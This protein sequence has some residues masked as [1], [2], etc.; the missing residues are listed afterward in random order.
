MPVEFIEVSD[1]LALARVVELAQ[2][3]GRIALDT[4]FQRTRT[5]YPIAGLYQLK[6]KQDCYLIDPIAI[7]DMTPLQELLDT[8]KVVK[9]MHACREDLTLFTH[10]L[11]VWPEGI[12][13]TQIAASFAGYPYMI[14]YKGLVAEVLGIELS[15]SVRTSNWLQRPLSDAQ[16]KYAAEDVEHL[17]QLHSHLCAELERLGRLNWYSDEIK[18]LYAKDQSDIQSQ[19]HNYERAWSLKGVAILRF[20]A[21]WEWREKW[22]RTRDKPRQWIAG[23]KL[24]HELARADSPA[25]EIFHKHQVQNSKIISQIRNILTKANGG[26]TSDWP[27]RPPRPLELDDKDLLVDLQQNAKVRAGDFDLPPGLLVNKKMLNNLVHCYRLHLPMPGWWQGW[28]GEVLGE[29]YLS[30]ITG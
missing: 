17:P 4:E 6:I 19:W 23:N 20:K 16:Q 13:D 12:F 14:G 9:I 24:L 2:K 26:T 5:Y 22:A 25:V 7:D 1:N 11:K 21:L 28:R 29:N 15:K 30:R 10:H 27:N 8:P 3:E 18:R